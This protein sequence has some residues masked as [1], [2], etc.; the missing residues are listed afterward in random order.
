V[1]KNINQNISLSKSL[2]LTGLQCQKYLW[3]KIHNKRVLQKPDENLKAIFA[4]G[5]E[6]GEKACKLFPGGKQIKYDKF[7]PHSER[8]ALTKKYIKDGYKTIYEATFEFDSVLVMVDILNIDNNGNFE[9]YEVKSSTWT[10]K[11]NLKS[12]DTYIKDVSIQYYVL[13]GCGFKISKACVTLLD[14]E[15]IRGEEENLEKLFFHKDIIKEVISLQNKISETLKSFRSTLKSKKAEPKIDIGWHCKNPNTCLAYDY[16]WKEQRNI[17]EYS[18]FNIFPLSKKS[19]ALELYKKGIVNIQSIPISE[20][21]TKAQKIKVDLVK[22]NDV[23]IDKN[24]IKL[25]LKSFNYPFYYFDFETYQ[26]AIPEFEGV[27]PFQ[28]I[29]FQYSLHIKNNSSKLGHIEFLAQSGSDPREDLVKQLISDIPPDVTVLAFNASFEKSVLVELAKRFPIYR[30]RLQNIINNLVDLAD[31]FR[32]K[33]YYHPEMKGK[34]SI[35]IILPLLVP[36]M[37]EEYDNLEIQNGSQ[38]MQSFANLVKISDQDEIKKIR[39]NLIKYCE[40]DTLAMV[41]IHDKLVKLCE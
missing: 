11:K 23:V 13:N 1:E 5:D 15:Y 24:A 14:G 20:K 32:K 34:F 6:V 8:I 40:L 12:I 25:F 30:E 41:K 3:L 17:P 33:Y 26:Q 4:T 31:P 7:T 28:Q 18:V 35:K 38:A 21:L 9:I 27:K 16:C 2:Y 22:D 39:K 36:E 10:S 29:P 37:E 19:K